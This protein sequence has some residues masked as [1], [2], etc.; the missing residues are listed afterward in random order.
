MVLATSH[1]DCLLSLTMEPEDPG[2]CTHVL[3]VAN[4]QLA[5]IVKAPCEEHTLIV[6]IERGMTATEH[7]DGFF[8]ANL[9]D[10]A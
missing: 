4:A 6:T 1:L 2:W 5:M 9:L 10:F 7:I 8:G 3:F